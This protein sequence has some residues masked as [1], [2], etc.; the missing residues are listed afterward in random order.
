MV[1]PS[2]IHFIE[3]PGEFSIQSAET[4]LVVSG[5]QPLFTLGLPMFTVSQWIIRSL[6]WTPSTKI[7]FF[8][9]WQ[10]IHLKDKNKIFETLHVGLKHEWGLWD[11]YWLCWKRLQFEVFVSCPFDVLFG[12]T[13]AKMLMA[14]RSPMKRAPHF[15]VATQW[16]PKHAPH[17][18]NSI[19]Y[20]G[21][22]AHGSY[23]RC[24]FIYSVYTFCYPFNIMPFHRA[25]DSV[26]KM[27][28]LIQSLHFYTPLNL[29]FSRTAPQ[30]SWPWRLL[31]RTSLPCII[32]RANCIVL[33]FVPLY[34]PKYSANGE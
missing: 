20:E 19:W 28:L 30:V 16:P 29:Q 3:G 10:K 34:L 2:G 4:Q 18:R 5:G 22:D 15:L 27:S 26:T 7:Y 12:V 13:Y 17:L 14:T 8:Y 6:P 21:L 32:P 23:L 9:L 31:A 24:V 1:D 33:Q 25:D 11:K